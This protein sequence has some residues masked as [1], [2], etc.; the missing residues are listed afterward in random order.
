ME[1]LELKETRAREA[2][3]CGID[4]IGEYRENKQKLSAERAELTKRLEQ[5]T[6]APALPVPERS[7]PPKTMG[8]IL[9]SE[10]FTDAKKNTALRT[11]VSHI[12]YAKAEQKITVYYHTP[13]E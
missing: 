2:Y 8:D 11:V 9:Q 6:A 7:A 1:K 4:T 10:Q 5:E 3:I 13:W 12:I